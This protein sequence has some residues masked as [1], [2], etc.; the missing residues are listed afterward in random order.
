MIVRVLLDTCAV[1]NLL[2]RDSIRLDIPLMGAVGG[3]EKKE[4]GSCGRTGGAVGCGVFEAPA[5]S[6]RLR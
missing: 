3:D 6:C 5:L 4:A 1:R 2:H